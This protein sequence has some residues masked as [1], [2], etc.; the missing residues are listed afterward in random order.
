M[1][2]RGFLQSI[3]VAASA[4]AIVRASSL[5]QVTTISDHDLVRMA[6][7]ARKE[8][9]MRALAEIMASEDSMPLSSAAPLLSFASKSSIIPYRRWL[10]YGESPLVVPEHIADESRAPSLVRAVQLPL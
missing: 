5:M 7:A 3:L 2:R 10:P 1:N 6:I 4:P 8:S 9:I